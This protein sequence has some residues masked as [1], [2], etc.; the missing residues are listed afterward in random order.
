MFCER[1]ATFILVCE[2][3]ASL[4]EV[5]PTHPL[6]SP[7][8][9]PVQPRSE[10]GTEGKEKIDTDFQRVFSVSHFCQVWQLIK[11]K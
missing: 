2:A 6:P 4:N 3:T 1:L 11:L 10:L 9:L 8:P 7:S 5:P